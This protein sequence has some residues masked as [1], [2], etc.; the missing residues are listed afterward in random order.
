[1]MKQKAIAKCYAM[2]A[3]YQSGKKIA[4]P[5]CWQPPPGH[6]NTHAC[7]TQVPEIS[8]CITLAFQT[9]EKIALTGTLSALPIR[10][11]CVAFD[12]HGEKISTTLASC[13][14]LATKAIIAAIRLVKPCRYPC[15]KQNRCVILGLFRSY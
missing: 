15:N 4:R 1:M 10:Q 7:M 9:R 11:I 12:E 13:V 14:L 6:H 8:L 2:H 5:A 3:S